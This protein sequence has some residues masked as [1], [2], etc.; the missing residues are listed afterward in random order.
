MEAEVARKPARAGRRSYNW[1]AIVAAAGLLLAAAIWNGCPLTFWDTRAYLTHAITLVPRTD[2]VIGYSLLIRALLPTG[3]VWTVVVF[4]CLA[5][6]ATLWIVARVVLVRVPALQFVAAAAAL[7]IASALPWIAGQ[8][9]PDIFTPLLVLAL[10]ALV[11][12]GAR[13]RRW[14]RGALCG[15]VALAAMVHVTHV[16]FGLALLGI[17]PLIA[18]CIGRR[19]G[20]W[21]GIGQGVAALALGVV[22]MLGFN[23]ARTGRLALVSGG[24]AFIL[25]HLVDSG[26]ASRVLEEHCG[27]GRADGSGGNGGGGDGGGGDGGADEYLLCQWR[28][29]LP[30]T[31][32]ELLWQE[33]LPFAPF[34]HPEET[35][36]E[37]RRLLRAS[38]R[39]HPWMHVQIAVNYTFGVLGHF[40]TGEGL[41][42]LA[43]PG[44]D[45]AIGRAAPGDLTA[46][47][48]SRQQHGRV[49]VTLLRAVHVP[50]GWTAIVL[51][52]AV[53]VVAA[54]RGRRWLAAPPVQLIA[55][56]LAAVVIYAVICGNTSGVYD[57]YEAR[58]VWVVAF[59]LWVALPAAARK[60][61]FAL[62]LH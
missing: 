1:V 9:M 4:Q 5:V 10:F 36:R 55:T 21:S 3:T 45:S 49:P 35:Q 27:G 44:L 43:R 28:D 31:P 15:L 50:V 37:T 26:I 25:A 51:A 12:G 40:G 19:P 11:H 7:T 47:R 2:R 48:S 22:A 13:L 54:R 30:M 34:D 38:L 61:R 53:L 46:L 24:D 42:S 59:A 56:A 52:L 41:D 23:Y 18:T 58:L 6:A 39:E 32:D 29:E 8:L 14:E 20:F 62:P 57:R 16:L 33:Q 17:A 60:R